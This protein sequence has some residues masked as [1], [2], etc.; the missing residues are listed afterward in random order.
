MFSNPYLLL[1]KNYSSTLGLNLMALFQPRRPLRPTR[2]ER[3]RVQGSNLIDTR[4][5]LIVNIV[6]AFNLPLRKDADVGLLT[7]E[8]LTGVQ[9]SNKRMDRG[10]SGNYATVKPFV[11]VWFQRN[12][13]RTTTALGSNPT[14]NQE[15]QLNLWVPNDD[16][17]QTNL[18]RMDDLVYFHIYDE[19]AIDLLEDDR[20][21]DTDIHQ[22]LEKRWL[23]TISIPFSTLYST[24]RVSQH[25]NKKFTYFTQF[26]LCP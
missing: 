7:T 14:W 20:R 13:C 26:K 24:G 19:V 17:S 1:L 16:Y 9:L 3:K 25:K 6:R 22:R 18:S 8:A 5:S 21:R 15:L 12:V 11:E 23:G 2:K 4:V 10:G